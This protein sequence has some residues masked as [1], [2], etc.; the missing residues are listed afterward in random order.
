[1]LDCS[2]ALA[3]LIVKGGKRL[4]CRKTPMQLVTAPDR[5]AVRNL[6]TMTQFVDAI[7]TR[8]P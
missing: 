3:K 7:V 2:T 4:A 5:A 1:M 8:C 6:I